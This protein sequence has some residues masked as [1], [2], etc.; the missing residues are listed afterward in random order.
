MSFDPTACAFSG[1]P[2]LTDVATLQILV[3]ATGPDNQQVSAPFTLYVYPP[4]QF[5]GQGLGLLGTYYN[6]T[7]FNS[8]GFEEI[9]PQVNFYWNGNSPAPNVGG[10]NWSAIWSGL[11]LAPQDGLYTFYTLSDDGACVW[12]NG[13]Q[14]YGWCGGGW[15]SGSIALQAG[16]LYNIT[17]EYN[18]GG[19]NSYAYLDGVIRDR[20]SNS[21]RRASSTVTRSVRSIIP[22]SP[23]PCPPAVWWPISWACRV[24]RA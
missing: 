13:Q 10:D 17:M 6:G 23:I 1:T 19:G 9:D 14:L 12:V 11:V 21:S 24:K 3:T 16:Q 8:F 4:T 2:A 20:T 18:Q 22:S 5:A 7:N 15:G